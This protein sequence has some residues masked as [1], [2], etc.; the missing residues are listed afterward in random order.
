M[1][2]ETRRIFLA[3]GL[4]IVAVALIG[5]LVSIG[6]LPSRLLPVASFCL[7]WANYL[8]FRSMA[9]PTGNRD[10]KFPVSNWKFLA[11]MSTAGVYFAGALWGIILYVNDHELYALLGTGFST[12]V[13][14]LCVR[15]AHKRLLT[16]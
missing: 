7:F 1:S 2:G 9:L 8:F 3:I 14:L 6:F 10:R 5:V 4:D 13:G 11:L 12:C 16:P 15:A